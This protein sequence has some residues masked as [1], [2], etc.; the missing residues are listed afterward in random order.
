MGAA[1]GEFFGRIILYLI[2]TATALTGICLWA[3]TDFFFIEDTY[4]SKKLIKPDMVI[5]S[6]TVNGIQTSD[7]TYIYHLK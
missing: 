2:I 6:K 1:I 4:K 3:F 7:T 5:E